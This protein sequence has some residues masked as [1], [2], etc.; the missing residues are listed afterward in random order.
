MPAG[1]FAGDA[2][3]VMQEAF[4]DC[5]RIETPAR[6]KE[7]DFFDVGIDAVLHAKGKCLSGIGVIETFEA[8]FLFGRGPFPLVPQSSSC[9]GIGAENAATIDLNPGVILQNGACVKELDSTEFAAYVDKEAKTSIDVITRFGQTGTENNDPSFDGGSDEKLVIA[10]EP[11]EP[12]AGLG[13][14]KA[15]SGLDCLKIRAFYSEP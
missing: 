1:P 8:Q 6:G 11:F 7:W 10:G 5:S 9:P 12:G 15:Q 13:I 2:A 14:V 3:L 4:V